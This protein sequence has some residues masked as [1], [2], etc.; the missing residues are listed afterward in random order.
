[1]TES[2]RVV[3]VG[4]GLPRIL[5]DLV[6]EII[7]TEPD[8]EVVEE[9]TE[10]D[11][12]DTSDLVTRVILARAHLLLVGTPDSELVETCTRLLNNYPRLRILGISAEGR[13]GFVSELRPHGAAVGELSPETLI[14]AI[15]G[16]SATK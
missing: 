15:R 6:R 8:I 13:R 14:A 16:S 9:L 2:T 5:R 11:L 3:V 10:V 7:Q 1:M 4:Q 12:V